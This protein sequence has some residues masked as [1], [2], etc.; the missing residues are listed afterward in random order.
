MGGMGAASHSNY[1][2]DDAK[3]EHGGLGGNANENLWCWAAKIPTKED[4]R[5]TKQILKWTPTEGLRNVGHP[6][7]RWRDGLD[8]FTKTLP[9][10]TDDPRAWEELLKDDEAARG[11]MTDYMNFIGDKS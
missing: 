2:G 7:A 8:Q 9:G 10:F 4:A 5:W 3:T 1:S 6:R 11:L